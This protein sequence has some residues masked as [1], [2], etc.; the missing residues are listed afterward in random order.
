MLRDFLAAAQTETLKT[1]IMN[2]ANLNQV[3]FSRY[4]AFCQDR[5]LLQKMNGGYAFTPQA[6]SLLQ[7]LNRVLSKAADLQLSV[8]LLNRTARSG[9][10]QLP[11]PEILFRPLDRVRLPAFLSQLSSE[12]RR[13]QLL[14]ED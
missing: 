7:S 10:Y 11:P 2:R 8:D 1:R 9:G 4:M 5:H 14:P 13:P 3:T 12:E 6:D